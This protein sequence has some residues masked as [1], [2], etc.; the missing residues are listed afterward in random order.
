MINED[1]RNSIEDCILFDTPAFDF[2]IIGKTLNNQIIYSYD[3]MI[4][5]F[6]K[7]HSCSR[8]VAREF[9]D[10]NTVE[11]LTYIDLDKCPVILYKLDFEV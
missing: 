2:S 11:I 9:I 8:E 6:M 3:L 7:D 5:E 10:K 1:L 4:E